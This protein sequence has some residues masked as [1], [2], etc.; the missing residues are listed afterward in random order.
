MK[1]NTPLFSNSHAVC[2]F[3]I[4]FLQPSA[5]CFSATSSVAGKPLQV[6]QPV[7]SGVSETTVGTLEKE[8]MISKR[9]LLFPL[10]YTEEKGGKHVS[11]L[12]D[13]AAVHEFDMNMVENPDW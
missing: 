12:V 7:Q 11:V 9:Y 2:L 1:A 5:A 10:K 8:L 3:L 4:L 6:E 13:G